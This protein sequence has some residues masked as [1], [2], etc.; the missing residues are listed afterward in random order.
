MEKESEAFFSSFATDLLIDKE[1]FKIKLQKWI[2]EEEQLEFSENIPES[3][4]I[5]KEPL[6]H[7]KQNIDAEGP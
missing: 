2:D 3:Q 1:Q 7:Y 6:K 5:L 4:P